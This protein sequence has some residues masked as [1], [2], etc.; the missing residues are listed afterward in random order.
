MDYLDN[1]DNNFSL[2]YRDIEYSF[3][4][5]LFIS[6][7]IHFGLA[8][9]HTL[10]ISFPTCLSEK[11]IHL[12]LFQNVRHRFPT[13]A[14]I[15]C[16]SCSCSWNKHHFRWDW[17]T[18]DRYG[19]RPWQW[20]RRRGLA[21][22]KSTSIFRALEIETFYWMDLYFISMHVQGVDFKRVFVMSLTCII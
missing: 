5:S 17:I 20:I 6:H 8:A 9:T 22:S 19:T 7:K 18:A 4:C 3:I 15:R 16:S 11:L 12:V 2:W 21:G 14:P 1:H 10:T 13:S